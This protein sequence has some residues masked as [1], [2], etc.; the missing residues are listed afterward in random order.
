VRTKKSLAAF[1]VVALL[2]VGCSDRGGS[3][4]PDARVSK[5]AAAPAD[6]G[7]L[8]GVCG[9]GTPTSA[10]AQ[11]VTA[12]EIRVGTFSDVG[13]NKVSEF[14]DAAK[15]FTAWCNDAG[16]INGRRIVSNTR[17]SKLFQVRQQMIGACRDDFALVGGGAALDGMGVKERL[18]CLLPDF[19]AQIASVENVGSDLQVATQAGGPSYDQYAGYYSW[20]LKEAYPKSAGAVGII[21]GDS[22]VTKV[23]G[24]VAEEGIKAAGG[25][26][27][28]NDLYPAAGLAD[29]TPYAQSIKSKKVKGLIFYGSFDQLAK[30]EQSLTNIGHHLDWI[31]A[32][33]NAYGSAFIELAGRQALTSQNNLADLSGVHPLE[34]ADS[35]P[36][37]KQVK[38]L[39]AKYAPGAAVTLPMLRAFSS[40]LLFAKAAASCGDQLTRKCV[41]DAARRETAWTGGGLQAPLDLS[42]SDRPVTCFNVEKATPEGWKPAD[43]APNKGAYRCDAPIVKLT[44]SYPKPV[45]LADVGKS[46]SDF[47]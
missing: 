28:Y 20:L 47:K 33:S 35:N 45:T 44:G 36:A 18:S 23:L 19:P 7:D 12:S 21:N 27:A 37:T 26:F 15:V 42:T 40:W 32:N 41:Y 34:N 5:A 17:D 22:A 9:P 24:Q 46:P 11:G 4:E 43:F 13:F 29:W 8:K 10:P 38:D 16:G 3:A 31:D 1:A 39:V 2:A 14:V 6:F 25:S 30:L